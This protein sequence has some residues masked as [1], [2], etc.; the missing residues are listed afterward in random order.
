MILCTNGPVVTNGHPWPS[1]H[2]CGQM[3]PEEYA[4]VSIVILGRVWN[5]HG[6]EQ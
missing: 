6:T 3:M 4:D 2:I 1:G 5:H